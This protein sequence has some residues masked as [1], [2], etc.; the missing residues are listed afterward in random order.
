M[1]SINAFILGCVCLIGIRNS[2]WAQA[3]NPPVG[4]PQASHE[5]DIAVWFAISGKSPRLGFLGNAPGQ[6]L[7]L[8]AVRA[9]WQ[10][11]DRSAY[12]LAYAIDF[13]PLALTTQ[14]VGFNTNRRVCP[15]AEP[16]LFSAVNRIFPDGRVYG[17]GISPLGAAATFR[18]K[19]TVQLLLDT[20]VGAL[21][22]TKPVP[23]TNGSRFNFTASV[24]AGAAIMT[25]D[26]RGIGFGY[27]F[28]HLSNA[29]LAQSNP[30]LA[31][32]MAYLELLWRR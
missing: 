6:R 1:R 3:A 2:A 28:H 27:R 17:F 32:H 12:R 18:P 4:I 16:C 26:D 13:I 29:R 31:S 15:P 19:R 25:K 5:R 7:G 9:T 30:G 8:A 24:G 11:R 21:W 20:T 23:V 10:L 22:F 14:P